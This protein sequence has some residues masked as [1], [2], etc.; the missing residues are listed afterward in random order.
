MRRRGSPATTPLRQWRVRREKRRL[1]SRSR[2]D[3]KDIEVKR[4]R[5]DRFSTYRFSDESLTLVAVD[6]S[7]KQIDERIDEQEEK[8]RARDGRRVWKRERERGR[9]EKGSTHHYVRNLVAR[10]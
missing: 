2:K 5:D 8:E 1:I 7:G 10:F 6:A 9:R 4:E 3:G